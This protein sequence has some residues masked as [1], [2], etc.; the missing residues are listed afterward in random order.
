[1]MQRSSVE[2][3]KAF[4]GTTRRAGGDKRSRDGKQELDAMQGV[5]QMGNVFEQVIAMQS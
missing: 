2:R 5:L 4:M 1:M 3:V